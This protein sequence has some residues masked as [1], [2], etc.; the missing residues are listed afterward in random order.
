MTH[1][2]E[3]LDLQKLKEQF[4][5][6]SEKLNKQK[7]INEKILRES[8]HEKLSYVEK[9]YRIQLGI[10]I[11]VV[12][13]LAILF[14]KLHFHWGFVLLMGIIALVQLGLDTLCY[15][16]LD[17]RNLPN[18]SMTSAI[19]KVAKYKKAHTLRT[20]IL[21]APSIALI[22]WTILIASGYSWNIPI[23]LLSST[24]MIGAVIR[25]FLIEKA[26]LRR[27]DEV[28]EDIKELKE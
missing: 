14:F 23:I 17:P 20:N 2:V 5:L 6:I 24:L 21:I 7:I 4:N 12:P 1:N 27:I 8:M 16:I 13:L 25:G 28:L 22:V 11:L 19:E 26:N 18:L 9:R 3:S 15:R 10:T